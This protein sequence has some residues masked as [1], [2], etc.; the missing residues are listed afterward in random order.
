[1]LISVKNV[2][3]ELPSADNYPSRQDWERACWRKTV[4]SPAL[5][6]LITTSNERKNFVLRALAIDRITSGKKYREIGEE[7]W[8]SPQ[9]ISSIKKALREQ[10]YRSYRERGKTERKKKVYSPNLGRT[11]KKYSSR[12][13]RTKYGVIRIPY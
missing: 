1:M 11:R 10:N 2:Y 3:R 8:L 12:R 4:K 5:L 7:L 9:T 6:E 13:V